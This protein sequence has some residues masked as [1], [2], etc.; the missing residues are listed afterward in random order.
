M[1]LSDYLAEF[2]VKEG[3]HHVFQIIGGASVHMVNSLADAKGMQYICVQHEQAGAMAAEA[4]SRITKNMGAAMATSGP[5]MTNLITGIACAYFDSIPTLYITGQVNTFESKEGR[6]VRQVGFQET[7]IVAVVQ[8]LTKYAVRVDNASDIRYELEKAVYIAKSGRPGPVIVD[9][10]MNIQR[11]D[12]KPQ[13]LK[14]FDPKEYVPDV[15]AAS[16][17]KQKIHDAWKK[18]AQAKRPVLIAG[19]AIRY[20]DQIQVFED[21]VNRLGIPVVS[22]WSGIDVLPHDHPLYR[23]QMGVYGNRAANFTIQNSDCILSIGS[24]LD[25]R[26]TGGKPET[27]ARE[28]FKI[29]VDIDR[30]EIYKNRGFNP[31]IGICADVR[32]VIPL[33]LKEVKTSHEKQADCS[34]WVKST[35]T[36]TGEFPSVLPEWRKRTSLVDPYVFIER[37]SEL[38]PSNATVVTDCGANLTWTVQAF[39][40]RRGQRLFS[41][42]G[43]SPMGYAFPAAI[44]AS[45]ALGNKPVIGIIGDGGVQINIQ[46]LQT[47]V[48]YKVPVKLFILNN[49]SYGIIMQ[50]QEMYFNG[51]YEATIPQ[52]G[53]SMPDFLALAKAYGLPSVSISTHKELDRKIK[54]VLAMKGPVVCDVHLP[55]HA[56]LIPK[57]SF[58]NPIEDLSPALSDEVFNRHM[59][60]AA[61]PRK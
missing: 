47:L 54:A 60:I 59:L 26:I 19:G 20:A 14:R 21:L 58:G 57:L 24:R 8:S 42:M 53:Y 29:V 11:A 3:I 10:P 23:G 55:T 44:G 36:W 40:V 31:D 52:K 51:K 18:L 45:I 12:I 6:K 30:A 28:A 1:K 37:L 9:V 25:T 39:H 33:F 27:F 2:L 38:L 56:K 4:Y 43:N 13:T 35:K 41:A 46:E 17:V 34:S 50:F 7:D 15:D 49:H 5:G 61:L 32:D 48:H 22:T 16:Y